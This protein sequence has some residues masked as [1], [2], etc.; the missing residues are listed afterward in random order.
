MTREELDLFLF[1]RSFYSF[2]VIEVRMEV[3]ILID[4]WFFRKEKLR[5]EL[6][7]ALP[8]GIVCRIYRLF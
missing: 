7:A 2:H 1:K 4:E 3:I 5:R 8:L 6:Q